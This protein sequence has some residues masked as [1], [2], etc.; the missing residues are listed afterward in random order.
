MEKLLSLKPFEF[1]LREINKWSGMI[2]NN[3]KYTTDWNLFIVE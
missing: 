3:K 1:H 2:Q